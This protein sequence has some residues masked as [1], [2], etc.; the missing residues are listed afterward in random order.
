[1]HFPK[2][3]EY[4]EEHFKQLP[5][6]CFVQYGNYIGE[7]LNAASQHKVKEVH[8]GIM[9]GKAVKLAAGHLDTHSRNVVM[10]KE[11]IAQ[12]VR[13]AGYPD[14]Y[15]EQIKAIRLARELESM[16]PFSSDEPFFSLLKQR[17]AITAGT[18]VKGYRLQ[19][20][21]IN[22]EGEMLL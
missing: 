17:C 6:Y 16:F 20:V 3:P 7:A 5:P 22:N 1:M 8:L 14:D 4:N 18:V 15:Q 21:L 9:I 11:F 13:E 2:K 10:D 12:L 19:V